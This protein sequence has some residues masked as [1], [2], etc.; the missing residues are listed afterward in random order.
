MRLSQVRDFVAVADAGSITAAA[1][2]LGVSQPG[3]TKSIGSLEAELNVPL[4]LRS[5]RGVSLTRYGSAF[6]ARAR[7]AHGELEKAR[8]DVMQLAGGAS[9]RVRSASVPLRRR[10]SCPVPC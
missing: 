2:A 5:A 6:Y 10:W 7:A 8:S 3:L 4:F 9:G 1:R